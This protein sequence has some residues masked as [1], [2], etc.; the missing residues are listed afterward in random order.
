MKTATEHKQ[1][2]KL[3]SGDTLRIRLDSWS[4][5]EIEIEDAI[6][7]DSICVHVDRNFLEGV[8][9]ST[10][11]DLKY[12]KGDSNKLFLSNLV[13]TC[14]NILNQWAKETAEEKA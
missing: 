10:V 1:I 9:I 2:I 11:N 7:K 5:P 12:S 13:K 14:Q 3:V 8:L 4:T 6:T